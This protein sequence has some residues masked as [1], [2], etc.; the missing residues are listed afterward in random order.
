MASL[1]TFPLGAGGAGSRT[2]TPV[3]EPAFVGVTLTLQAVVAT[4]ALD[5]LLTNGV[6]IALGD[7]NG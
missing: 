7:V 1:P 5:L 2:V 6:N 4:L 3:N